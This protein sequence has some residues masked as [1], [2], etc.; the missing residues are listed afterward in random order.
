MIKPVFIQGLAVKRTLPE[1]T[2]ANTARGGVRNR[3]PY[4]WRSAEA[5]K[6]AFVDDRHVTVLATVVNRDVSPIFCINVPVNIS[7]TVL[8]PENIRHVP[9]S[10]AFRY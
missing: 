6:S 1:K 2:F 8:V 4:K 10:I 7:T 9:N 3:H 5:V